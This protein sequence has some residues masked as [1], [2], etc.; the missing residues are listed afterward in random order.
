MLIHLV[1][2]VNVV[3]AVRTTQAF[4]NATRTWMLANNKTT[5]RMCDDATLG[6]GD[7]PQGFIPCPYPS[8]GTGTWDDPGLACGFGAGPAATL[9]GALFASLCVTLCS[10]VV[11]THAQRLVAK[12]QSKDPRTKKRGKLNS[13]D[14]LEIFNMIGALFTAFN[15]IDRD[16]RSGNYNFVSANLLAH[17]GLFWTFLMLIWWVR[18]STRCSPSPI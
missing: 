4:I 16:G 14:Q 18:F 10:L 7:A 5:F 9:G 8:F 17:G 13:F 11:I 3:W 1:S 2:N 6:A 12:L 15:T